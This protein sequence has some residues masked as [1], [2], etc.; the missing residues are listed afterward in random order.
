MSGAG[1]GATHANPQY[2]NWKGLRKSRS[3]QPYA[4][5]RS[6]LTQSTAPK[7]TRSAPSQATSTGRAS[8]TPRRPRGPASRPVER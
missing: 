3:T 7:S 8:A 2:L 6:M 4:R 5:S 1:N